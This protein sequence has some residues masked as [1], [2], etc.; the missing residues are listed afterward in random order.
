MEIHMCHFFLLPTDVQGSS[1]YISARQVRIHTTKDTTFYLRVL[2]NP[3]IEHTSGVHV[4][5]YVPTYPGWRED[6]SA[7]GLEPDGGKWAEVHD[8]GWL[9]ATKSPH[10]DIL[11]ENKRNPPLSCCS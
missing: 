10:W 3:I 11:P 7:E 5:P 4:A 9:R 6:F 2:S 8:F 1:L